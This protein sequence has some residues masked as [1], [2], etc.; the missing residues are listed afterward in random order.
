MFLKV[1]A[2]KNFRKTHTETVLS[3]SLFNE[4]VSLQT[5]NFIKK[6]LQHRRFPLNIA[7]FLRKTFYRT[8][9]VAASA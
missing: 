4:V 2:L 3:E 1:G 8:P 7:K 6:R 5:G 9:L